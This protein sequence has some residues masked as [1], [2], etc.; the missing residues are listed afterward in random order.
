MLQGCGETFMGFFREE[1]LAGTISYLLE[2]KVLDIHRVMVHPRHFR[3]GVATSLLRHLLASIPQAT[4]V[5]VSTGSDN[6]PARHLYHHLGFNEVG[7]EEVAPGF[8]MTCF[9]LI[10]AGSKG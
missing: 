6:S 10:Q 1:A 4:V 3:K 8:W 2:G 7:E 9:R 5:E